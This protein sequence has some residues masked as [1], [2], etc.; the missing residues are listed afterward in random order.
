MPVLI[1]VNNV[2]HVVGV[3][4]PEL[5]G[6][7]L[8]ELGDLVVGSRFGR[9]DVVFVCD[10]KPRRHQ[11]S[12]DVRVLFSGA[13]VSA[14]DVIIRLVNRSTAPRRLTVISNDRE[15]TTSVRRRRAKV[16]SAEAFLGMLAEDARGTPATRRSRPR[17]TDQHPADQRQVEHWLR[18]FGVESDPIS[19]LPSSPPRPRAAAKEQDETPEPDAANRAGASI[20]DAKRLA[21]IDP[22]DLED[23]DMRRWLDDNE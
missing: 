23:L 10:G 20:D 18:L 13:G 8:E 15:I 5:A 17:T 19:D 9:E 22:R 1:D 6:I 12:S 11:T 7:D 14:D 4:P 2:L 21:D 16:V 3:L